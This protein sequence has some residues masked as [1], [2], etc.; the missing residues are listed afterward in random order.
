MILGLCLFVSF[1]EKSPKECLA[2]LSFFLC[3]GIAYS[4]LGLGLGCLL[5]L[6]PDLTSVTPSPGEPGVTT[7]L[8]TATSSDT[9]PAS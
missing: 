8:T 5:L 6:G 1:Y 3:A 2:V 7:T 4:G 9:A